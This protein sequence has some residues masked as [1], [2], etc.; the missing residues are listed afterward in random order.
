[1]AAVQ[2]REGVRLVFAVGIGGFGGCEGGGRREKCC[3]L[4]EEE[5]DVEEV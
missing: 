3:D 4:G 2:G 1:M 5:E